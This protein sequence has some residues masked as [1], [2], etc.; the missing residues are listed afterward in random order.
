MFYVLYLVLLIIG[1]KDG[2]NI[3]SS[4]EIFDPSNQSL[5][6]TLP[7][8]TVARNGHAAVGLTVCGG[9]DGNDGLQTCETLVGQQWTESHRLQQKRQDH[10]MW[11]SPSQGLMLI[12]GYYGG[13]EKTTE[14][15]QDNGNGWSLQYYTR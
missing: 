7:N 14:R 1:G 3:L 2:D 9:W 10:V 11:Q 15:L 5:T 12:G 8:M 6:C 13:T 4:V